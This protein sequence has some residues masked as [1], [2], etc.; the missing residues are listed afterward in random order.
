MPEAETWS[1]PTNCLLHIGVNR[2]LIRHLKGG[3]YDGAGIGDRA[4]SK[5]IR[6]AGKVRRTQKVSSLT[7]CIQCDS[8]CYLLLELVLL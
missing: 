4:V 8:G 7:K 6:A 2:S 5:C 3:C 1:K